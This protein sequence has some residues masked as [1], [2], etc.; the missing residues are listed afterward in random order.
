ML[1]TIVKR[2]INHPNWA[3]DNFYTIEK[4]EFIMGAV[5]DGCS[6][7][8]DSFWASKT[9]T[10]LFD[11]V[12]KEYKNF[13]SFKNADAFEFNCIDF[14]TN[15]A[16]KLNVVKEYLGLTEMELLATIV[17]FIYNKKNKTLYVKFV[18]DGVFFYTNSEGELF[19]VSNDENNMPLYLGYYCHLPE[20]NLY[21]FLSSRAT[22]TINEVQDFS[23]C[24][25]GIFSFR[26]TGVDREPEKNPILY[27]VQD[28]LMCNLSSGLSRKFNLLTKNGW[29]IEDDLTVIRYKQV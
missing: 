24:S 20:E 18:G 16:K 29:I 5:F 10:I 25:D 27:L 14:I 21:N 12:Q 11:K 13:E 6:G 17:F 28:T 19:E 4:D 23:I 7:G 1:S 8:N 2:S 9:M 3:E 26:F 15:V 22:Y